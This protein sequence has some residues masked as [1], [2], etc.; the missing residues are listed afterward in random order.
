MKHLKSFKI[1]ETIGYS[2]L[3]DDMWNE[4][5]DILLELE[6]QTGNIQKVKLE[7]ILSYMMFMD[8][9]MN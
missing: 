3:T 2:E 9:M 6:E 1:F 5:S 8:S 7:F 4:I